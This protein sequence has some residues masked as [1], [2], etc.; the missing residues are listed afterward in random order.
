MEEIPVIMAS[1]QSI[2]N[3][4]LHVDAKV[5][6]KPEPESVSLRKNFEAL[7]KTVSSPDVKTY[8]YR[9]STCNKN[10]PRK[11]LQNIWI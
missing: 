1:N 10:E 11:I 6:H 3:I 9:P 7:L 8:I 2:R 5:T 4:I